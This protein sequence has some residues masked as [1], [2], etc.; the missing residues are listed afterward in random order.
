MA[1]ETA[2]KKKARLAAEAAAASKTTDEL[3]EDA[4]DE[5]KDPEAP[6][7]ESEP[8]AEEVTPAVKDNSMV[9]VASGKGGRRRMTMSA[10][11]A[12]QEAEAVE[13]EDE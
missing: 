4:L 8:E 11:K 12:M 9:T 1:R 10:Y 6:E 5:S 7:Q 13:A 2:A 3:T